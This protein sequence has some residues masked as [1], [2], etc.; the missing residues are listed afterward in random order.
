MARVYLILS[1]FA[2]VLVCGAATIPRACSTPA[3]SGYPFCN[4]S[5][6]IDDRI[7]ANE[8]IVF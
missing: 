4:A 8:L 5:L 1:V 6:P 2:A 3:T 7:K